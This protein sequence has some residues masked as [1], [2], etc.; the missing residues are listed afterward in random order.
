MARDDYDPNAKHS[1]AHPMKDFLSAYRPG[2][3][4]LGARDGL[5]S[6]LS[7]WELERETAKGHSARD[8]RS[9]WRK[10]R[11]TPLPEGRDWRGILLAV[12][13][14]ATLG[15]SI[16]A[17]VKLDRVLDAMHWHWM[18][19][20]EGDQSVDRIPPTIHWRSQ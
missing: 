16:F 13:V 11:R 3:G 1:P 6:D 20:T 14:A 9:E 5:D 10:Q 15:L 19:P 18:N 4:G 2:S 8:Y 12:G 17:L 7:Y